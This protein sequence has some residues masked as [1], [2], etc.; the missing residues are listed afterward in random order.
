MK[1]REFL[2]DGLLTLGAAGLLPGAGLLA[3]DGLAPGAAELLSETGLLASGGDTASPLTDVVEPATR[4]QILSGISDWVKQLAEAN[5]QMWALVARHIPNEQW[6]GEMDIK[7]VTTEDKA[8]LEQWKKVLLRR[9]EL[10]ANAR[11]QNI[12]GDSIYQLLENMFPDFLNRA[13]NANAQKF[14]DWLK[15]F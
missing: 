3:G 9:D 6:Q 5:E 8:A 2:R 14:L 10:L 12:Q 4:E 13:H 7:L 15:D 11:L 1:R